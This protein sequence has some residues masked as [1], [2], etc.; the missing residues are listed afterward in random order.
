M[1]GPGWHGNAMRSWCILLL[2][3][4]AAAGTA[5]DEVGEEIARRHAARAG[6]AWKNLQALYAEGRTLVQGEVVAIRFWIAR[7]NRLRVET[8]GERD[9]T[10]QCFDGRLEPWYRNTAVTAGAPARLPPAER[11]DFIA[12]ADLDGP[13]ADFR[14][15]GCTVDYAG[16]DEVL[17]RPADKVLV[18]DQADGVTFLWVDRETAEIVKRSVFRLSGGRR[19]TVDTVFSDFRPVGG[20]PQPHH[21]ETK[22]AGETLYVMVLTRLEANPALPADLFAAPPGWPALLPDQGENNPVGR[23]P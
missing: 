9:R 20:V 4:L 23:R 2:A 10:V 13:L 21:I 17:G 19:V 16:S 18:M 5:A 22:Q 7:P 15:K 11:R 3:G 12:N 14:A 8:A 6:G 1:A